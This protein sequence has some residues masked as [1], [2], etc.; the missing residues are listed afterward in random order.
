MQGRRS[1]TG[2]TGL[3]LARYFDTSPEFWLGIQKD[4]DLEVA[5]DEF[6]A[7]VER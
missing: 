1:I 5:R 2:E 6:A 4:Y 3:R 7:Q